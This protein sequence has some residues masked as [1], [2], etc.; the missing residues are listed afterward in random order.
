MNYGTAGQGGKNP[1]IFSQHLTLI[2]SI[3]KQHLK[4]IL[5]RMNFDSSLLT[6]LY[7]AHN[8]PK[9][10]LYKSQFFQFREKQVF[11]ML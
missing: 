8:A 6:K 10:H 2:I 11:K 4:H 7:F 1:C 9:Q 3:S 5:S